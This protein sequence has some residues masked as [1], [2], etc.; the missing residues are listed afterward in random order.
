[1]VLPTDHVRDLHLDVVDHV[2][3]MK[4]PRAIRPPHVRVRVVARIREIE[5]DFAANE[6]VHDHMLA[7]RT[8]SERALVFKDMACVLKLLQVALVN[9]S[10]LTLKIRAEIPADVRTFVPINSQ[11]LQSFVNRRGGLLGVALGV[12]IFDSKNELAPVMMHKE[13]VEKRSARATD[14]QIT[15]GRWRKPNSNF[16]RHSLGL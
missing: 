14:V 6:I 2:D 8:K 3:E 7:R 15:R 10:A 16:R 11:P 13:P 9:F 5:I 4:N 12:G 1:M